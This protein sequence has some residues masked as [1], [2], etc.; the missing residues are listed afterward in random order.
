MKIGIRTPSIK[1]RISARTSVKRVVRHSLGIKAPKGYGW[2]T[3]PQ[4]ATYNRVYNRTTRGCMLTLFIFLGIVFSL[5][6]VVIFTI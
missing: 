3:N 6:F 4:K 2:L 5:G 1:K